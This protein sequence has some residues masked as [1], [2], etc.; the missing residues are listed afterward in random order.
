MFLNLLSQNCLKFYQQFSSF[1]LS[2][3]KL[4][5]VKLFNIYYFDRVEFYMFK[6]CTQSS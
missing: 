6:L 4:V 3:E 5:N 1:P 2:P